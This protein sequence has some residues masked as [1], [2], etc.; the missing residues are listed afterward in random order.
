MTAGPKKPERSQM[1][2]RLDARARVIQ[3]DLE[4]LSTTD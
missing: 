3:K 1:D 2:K 4:L